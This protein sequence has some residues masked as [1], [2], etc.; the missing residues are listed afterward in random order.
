MLVLADL[1]QVLDLVIAALA[2]AAFFAAL[3]TI[4]D[5]RKA[6]KE[7]ND[8]HREAIEAQA[9]LLESTTNAYET[10][11][12]ERV[13]TSLCNQ[14]LQRLIRLGN[15][16]QLLSEL[17]LAAGQEAKAHGEYDRDPKEPNPTLRHPASPV[18]TLLTRFEA[19]LRIYE[20][21]GGEPQE[22]LQAWA[23]RQKWPTLPNSRI[24][25]S[26]ESRLK[27]LA[28]LIGREGEELSSCSEVM[29]GLYNRST[30]QANDSPAA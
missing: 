18:T 11:I 29:R 8:A 16:G 6:Q 15:I 25:D 3:V 20:A 28:V 2:A 12:A 7:A 27:A 17:A 4:R 13:T 10:E 24:R 21:L 19:E 1:T 5:A 26:S 14:V 23:D 9:Q 22:E 30:G